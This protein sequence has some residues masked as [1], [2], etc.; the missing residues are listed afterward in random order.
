MHLACRTSTDQKS[1]RKKERIGSPHAAGGI[2][3]PQSVRFTL[4]SLSNTYVDY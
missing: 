2:L 3:R 4:A 1:Q